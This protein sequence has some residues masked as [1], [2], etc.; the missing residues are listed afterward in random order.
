[1][2]PPKQNHPASHPSPSQHLTSFWRLT[3]RQYKTQAK[4]ST[5]RPDPKSQPIFRGYKSNLP[6]S[7][8]YIHLIDYGLWTQETW[9]GIRYGQNLYIQD[10]KC[11]WGQNRP[12]RPPLQ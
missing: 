3:K 6:T 5:D 11:P 1:M 7:L 4:N 9:C 12:G 2:T 8:T 10:S